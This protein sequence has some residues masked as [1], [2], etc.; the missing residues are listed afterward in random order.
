MGFNSEINILIILWVIVALLAWLLRVSFHRNKVALKNGVI[1]N[2]LLVFLA[3]AISISVYLL[4]NKVLMFIWFTILLIAIVVLTIFSAILGFLLLWNAWLVWRREQHSLANSLT[5]FL[6]IYF[7]VT[8]I[9]LPLGKDIFPDNFITIVAEINSV[10]FG[11]LLFWLLNYVTAFAIYTIF[12]SRRAH[13]YIIVLGAGLLNGDQVSPL[14]KNRIDAA[15]TAAQHQYDKFKTRPLIILSG[16][17]GSDETIPEGVAMM[18]YAQGT[19]YPS[20]KLIAEQ[21]SK[22]TYENM[23][24]SK[25]IVLDQGLDPAKGAFATSD[26]HV[27]RAATYAQSVGLK[28]DGFGAHTRRYFIYNALL[29]EYIAILSKHKKLHILGIGCLLIIAILITISGW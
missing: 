9:I 24:F 27:F 1:G 5:L 28:V 17:Q 25:Q 21:A 13:D 8:P 20:D 18:A 14:L 26:Y 4:G 16:G 22:T 7:I 6:G 10:I 29:R 3:T 15:L 11:Y 23:L 12:Q 19:G 2:I